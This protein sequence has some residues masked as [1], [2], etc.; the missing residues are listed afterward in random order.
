MRSVIVD[1]GT[2]NSI[3]PNYDLMDPGDVIVHNLD[4]ESLPQ[5]IILNSSTGY[6][7]SENGASVDVQLVLNSLPTA[8]V[9]L[10]TI[11]SLDPAEGTVS[12]GSITFT[13]VDWDCPHTLTVFGIDD[14]V[15]DA[16]KIYTVD[17]G[18]TSSADPNWNGIDPGDIT[19]TNMAY[20]NI[21]GYNLSYPPGFYSTISGIGTLINFRD[22]DFYDVYTPEDEGYEYVPI[23]FTFYYIGRPYTEITVYTNGFASF[24]PYHNTS[25]TLLMIFYLK[26]MSIPISL[27]I[28]LPPGGMIWTRDCREAMF[29]MKPQVSHQIEFLQLNG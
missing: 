15:L 4:D 16:D 27:S 23:G 25:N 29:I 22:V 21:A 12:P 28:S 19:V 17:L 3:D 6:Y 18:A 26:K 7:T 9:T 2:A 11:Q 14:F 5:V 20:R 10:G 24:N 1:L 13:P 8:D